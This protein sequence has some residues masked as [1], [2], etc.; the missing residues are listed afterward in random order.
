[1]GVK[2]VYGKGPINRKKHLELAKDAEE[3]AEKEKDWNKKGSLKNLARQHR[4]VAETGD[5]EGKKK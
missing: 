4:N 2:G 3:K 1:M 5:P